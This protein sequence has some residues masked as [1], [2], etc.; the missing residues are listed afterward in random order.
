M[1]SIRINGETYEIDS[2]KTILDVCN[3][4]GIYIPSLCYHP[5]IPPSGKCGICV[6]KVNSTEFV[7]SCATKIK[8]GMF[9]E[10]STNEVKK[11]ALEALNNFNDMPLMPYSEEIEEMWKYFRPFMPYRARIAEKTNSIEFDPKFCINC[12]LCKKMCRDM[13]RLEALDV[14]CHLLSESDCIN[15]GQCIQVCPSR[16]LKETSSIPSFVKSLAQGK[17]L[18]LIVDAA[19]RVSMGELFEGD[20]GIDNTSRV[21][22]AAREM[23]FKY[24]VDEGI[25]V[26]IMIKSFY[27]EYI[28]RK[29]QN[30]LPLIISSCPSLVT[31]MEKLNHDLLPYMSNMSSPKMLLADV[32]RKSVSKL[33]NTDPTNIYIVFLTSC[34]SSKDEILRDDGFSPVD[35]CLT[36]KEFA[37]LVKNFN[38]TFNID[39]SDHF[40]DILGKS[41]KGT[42]LSSISGGTSLLLLHSL[43]LINDEVIKSIQEN[44]FIKIVERQLENQ[45]FKI[46][47]LNGN[48][49]V[50]EFFEKHEYSDIDIV[51]A[52]ACKGG[53]IGGAGVKPLRSSSET[54]P[55]VKTIYNL[56]EIMTDRE[57]LI[58]SKSLDICENIKI[59]KC[60]QQVFKPRNSR[61]LN[62]KRQIGSTPIVAYGNVQGHCV[63]YAHLFAIE[64]GTLP[65]PLNNVDLVEMEKRGKIIIFCTT[66]ANG[67][68]PSN[69]KKFAE[70]L[71]NSNIDLSN[72]NFAVCALG[73]TYYPDFCSAGVK[74]DEMLRQHNA[75]ALLPITSIDTYSYDHG[76]L[77][78]EVWTEKV[79]SLIGVKSLTN[80]IPA[81]YKVEPV[82]S[83]VSDGKRPVGFDLGILTS[84][85][86]LTTDDTCPVIR[87]YQI[88]LPPSLT[89]E[90]GEF[91]EILP[92]N[93]PNVVENVL[94]ELELDPFQVYHIET[95]LPDN[96][97]TVPHS[98]SA[99]ELFTYYI[100]LSG[101][102]SRNLLRAYRQ[103]TREDF[104]RQK[105]SKILD[106]NLQDYHNF[107][108]NVNVEEFLLEFSRYGRPPLDILISVCDLIRPRQYCIASA[109]ISQPR[110]VD[111]IVAD[112]VFSGN[113]SRKGLCTSFLSRYGTTHVPVR[114]LR[115]SLRYPPDVSSPLLMLALGA[116][117][118]L[119][120]G[121]LQHREH[122]TCELGSAHL[123][124]GCGHKNS[125]PLIESL[126]KVYVD[127]GTL[128]N[129]RIA[130]SE[131]ESKNSPITDSMKEDGSSLWN[132]WK[133]K[134]T[135][136]FICGFPRHIMESIKD[137]LIQI[138]ITEGH[139]DKKHADDF[140]ELHPLYVEMF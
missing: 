55:R 3:E 15:C 41:S 20:V 63:Q 70:D 118:S 32:L 50:R 103:Y 80:T 83:K 139:M 128:N 140:F 64:I 46:A 33:A 4:L 48:G 36:C 5:S 111:F 136:L 113:N 91:L 16:A 9:V 35:C 104:V 121:F 106:R 60:L 115:R 6:V 122:Q 76:E 88:K 1:I 82:S 95:K 43:G 72:L 10:T 58:T 61:I 124:F 52:M 134:K 100:D 116:G 130:Y 119:V 25:G 101:I 45:S 93:D 99:R 13:Q 135:S 51:E 107:I 125:L 114:I 11:K 110:T 117:I 120:L 57:N 19:S 27:D 22:S 62:L 12:N 54:E 49:A 2:D 132:I 123:Y 68:F 97:N 77:N 126:L 53:C 24:V 133:N 75:K 65:T 44:K 28:Q 102:P 66:F 90:V 59:K 21:I 56:S 74:L 96:V 17:L 94:T 67:E 40:D 47:I 98:V 23:G 84:R 79:L 86:V 87:R 73:S 39:S 38:L 92:Q 30:K 31:Y 34:V 18:V 129:L 85:T 14:D 105:L 137:M 78:L 89:Y 71:K 8:N 26:D 69:A 108:N 37:E 112:N 29:E 131:E 42:V 138:S 109:P 81:R 7:L 127:Q